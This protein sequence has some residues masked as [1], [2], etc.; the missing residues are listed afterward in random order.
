MKRK[1]RREIYLYKVKIDINQRK[2][3]QDDEINSE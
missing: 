2:M 1:N 3:L